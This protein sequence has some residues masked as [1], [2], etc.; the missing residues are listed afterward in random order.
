MNCDFAALQGTEGDG[1]ALY[2]THAKS[3]QCS[4]LLS[5]LIAAVGIPLPASRGAQQLGSSCSVKHPSP[6]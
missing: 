2:V 4:L 6:Q 5:G 1:S 3:L